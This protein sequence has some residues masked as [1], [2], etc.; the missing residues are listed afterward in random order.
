[1]ICCNLDCYS[2]STWKTHQCVCSVRKLTMS[3]LSLPAVCL[4]LP[5]LFHSALSVLLSVLVCVNQGFLQYLHRFSVSDAEPS[6]FIFLLFLILF[7]FLCVDWSIKERK[8]TKGLCL[9]QVLHLCPTSITHDKQCPHCSLSS[10]FGHFQCFK[11]VKY[12]EQLKR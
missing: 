3:C 10:A 11:G 7:L 9:S 2:V 6:H 5:V 8:R 12:S 4:F 1:M